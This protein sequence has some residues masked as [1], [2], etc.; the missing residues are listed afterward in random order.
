MRG[1]KNLI[2]I[3]S[4]F[5]I[6]IFGIYV[7]FFGMA[8]VEIFF[9]KGVG[10]ELSKSRANRERETFE[11]SKPFINNMINTLSS[12]KMQYDLA[13]EKDKEIIK[14]NIKIEFAN[15]DASMIKNE[16]LRHFLYDMRGE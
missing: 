3:I 10:T 11:T 5:I 8:K 12:Y 9:N 6:L 14:N 4:S 1:F 13:S 16:N 15:F 2:I 7:L